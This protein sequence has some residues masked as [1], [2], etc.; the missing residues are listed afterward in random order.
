[1]FSLTRR[2]FPDRPLTPEDLDALTDLWLAWHE[3]AQRG[4]FPRLEGYH[5]IELK[6]WGFPRQDREKLRQLLQQNLNSME[7]HDS[8]IDDSDPEWL[9]VR[10]P[11]L[12]FSHPPSL[13]KWHT[14]VND[15]AFC[16][17]VALLRL[18]LHDWPAVPLGPAVRGG[19]L[20][21]CGQF[22]HQSF[23][24]KAL[25]PEGL[26]QGIEGLFRKAVWSEEAYV[27]G[28]LDEFR[29]TGE[30]AVPPGDFFASRRQ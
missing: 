30:I 5:A 9:T 16:G 20:V 1:M 25:W 15:D 21:I 24:L 2:Q 22:R 23:L 10:T 3:Q 27:L 8:E 14:L 11:F 26:E 18:I 6:L 7:V 28:A 19:T 17:L 4:S 12:D 13:A 29:R